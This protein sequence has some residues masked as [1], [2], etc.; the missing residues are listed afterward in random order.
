LAIISIFILSNL[1]F[2]AAQ[3]RILS[4]I[5]SREMVPLPGG[6]PLKAQPQFDQGAVDPA[7]KLGYMTV[8]TA[9]SA[10]QQKALDR[11]LAQQQD[12]RSPL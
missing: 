8:L 2:G 7:L 1:S 11:L 3:D 4:P 5:V 6:V 10:S 12:R 9:P